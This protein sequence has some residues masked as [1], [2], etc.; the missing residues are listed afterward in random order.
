MCVFGAKAHMDHK[1]TVVT[2][3]GTVVPIFG[4]SFWVGVGGA[5]MSLISSLL[6]FCVGRDDEYYM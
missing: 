1:A 6:Y 2:E 3:Q 5:F 4:W